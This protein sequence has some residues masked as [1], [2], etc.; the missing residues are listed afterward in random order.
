MP[1]L[2]IGA[3]PGAII[4]GIIGAAAAFLA[5]QTLDWTG[6]R[7]YTINAVSNMYRDW[8]DG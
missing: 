4:G 7:D 6:A 3:V 1:A 5:T 2:G 8:T